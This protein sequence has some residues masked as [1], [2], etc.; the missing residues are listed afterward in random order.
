MLGLIQPLGMI[1]ASWLWLFL[2]FS[3]L[4]MAMLGALRMSASSGPQWLDNFWLGWA[5]VLLILQLWHFAFPMNDIIMLL[6]AAG[7]ALSLWHSR[8]QLQLSASRLWQD[9][10]F[11][12][13][14]GG[15]ALWFASRSIELPA[16]FDTGY[17]DIQAV[18]WID[19]YAIVPGL[20]NLFASLAYNHPTY[21]YNA[22]LDFGLFS[23]R[24]VYIASGLLLLAYLA[25]ALHAAMQLWRNRRQ[26]ELRWSCIFAMLTIPYIL[27]YTGG[28]SG[29]T[30]FLTD[31][32]VDLLGFLTVIY[33]LDF[34]QDWQP[35]TNRDYLLLRLAVIV[36][37]GII[38]KQTYIVFGLAIASLTALIWLR[39]G[40]M[41]VSKRHTARLACGL[42]LL[43]AAFVLP[44]MARGVVTSG[45]IAY[46]VSIGRVELDWTIPRNQIETRQR[47]LATNTRQRGSDPNDVLGSWDWFAPW[48]RQLVDNFFHTTLPIAISAIALLLL[49]AG[50]LGNRSASKSALGMWALSPLLIMLVFWFVSFPNPKYAR[51]LF[52]SFAALS[53]LLAMLEWRRV[54][55]QMRVLGAF[56]LCAICLLYT[57]YVIVRLGNF[58]LPAGPSDG[59]YR[60]E[61]PQVR[62]FETESG[63]QLNVPRYN[64]QCWDLPL[65]CTDTPDPNVYARVPGDLSAGFAYAAGD[66]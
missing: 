13:L 14:F 10:A 38:V 59:F 32:V 37:V 61:Q 43:V 4:G 58:P 28:R 19:A 8:D 1:I 15:L 45:Y 63:L 34:L 66:G 47:L 39:R 11:F 2:L 23:G 31:T 40:G 29:I 46:P 51:W 33:W 56:V 17:R 49:A 53:V 30:H 26:S 35:R 7:A 64:G 16:A 36:A 65:P 55:P 52:W 57:A 6:L 3:G 48:L 18:M 44:W 21:L 50:K 20:G 54:S 24:S 5:L 42:C 60:R 27:Q 25:Y 9:K 22:L 12:L 62:I 41:A